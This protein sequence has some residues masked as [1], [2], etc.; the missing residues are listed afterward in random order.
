M[1]KNGLPFLDRTYALCHFVKTIFMTP[2][3]PKKALILLAHPQFQSSVLNRALL[4]SAC[5]DPRVVIR[6][7]YAL[8]PDFKIN[9]AAEQKALVDAD[10][11]IFQFPFYWYSTPFLLKKWQDEVLTWGFAF[12][13]LGTA[14]AGK[15]WMIATT[16]G[17]DEAFYQPG[18]QNPF[19]MDAF[20]SPLTQ[21]AVYCGMVPVPAI[22]LF[23]GRN[24]PAPQILAA[25]AE[26]SEA[27]QR[28]LQ[29]P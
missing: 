27:I 15:K 20:L 25:R 5:N 9:A 16:T 13:K 28:A 2:I 4:E 19:N 18:P 29:T 8:Y 6:D 26:Y 21:T 12:G 22:V 24:L 23:G 7:L 11:I 14:L 17:V 3:L 10:L 1:R